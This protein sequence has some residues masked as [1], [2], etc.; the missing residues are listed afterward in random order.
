M[1][2]LQTY[3]DQQHPDWLGVCDT[4]LNGYVLAPT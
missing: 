1:E 4:A 2:V 3:V